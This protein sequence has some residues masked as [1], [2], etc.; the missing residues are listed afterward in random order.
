MSYVTLNLQNFLIKRT[1][2]FQETSRLK[3]KVM[4]GTFRGVMHG[5]LIQT[6]I[7]SNIHELYCI[8]MYQ[9]LAPMYLSLNKNKQLINPKDKLAT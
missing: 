9:T 7:A 3:Q 2:Q 6:L 4:H 5:T 1:I 8:F